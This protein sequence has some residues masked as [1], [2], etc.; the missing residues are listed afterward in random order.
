MPFLHLDHPI[1]KSKTVSYRK[2]KGI[3]TTEF[4]KDIMDCFLLFWDQ[5]SSLSDHVQSY[6]M[7]LSD[8]LDKHAPEKTRCICDTHH[9]P[10]F[11]D[12]IKVEIILHCK[13]ERI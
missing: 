13:K 12:Q 8:A 7:I 10:W 5:P 11:N 9:Q 6:N 4:N 1:P 2:L 3:N